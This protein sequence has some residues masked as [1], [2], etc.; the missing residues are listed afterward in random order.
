LYLALEEIR[1]KKETEDR[2]LGMAGTLIASAILFIAGFAG[3]FMVSFR[4]FFIHMD[5]ESPW[6]YVVVG[7][8]AGV[9]AA[10]IPFT[11][12]AAGAGTLEEVRRDSRERK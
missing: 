5:T 8:V 12:R 10:L 7:L 9:I 6:P 4:F 3:G 2:L 1:L 11:M